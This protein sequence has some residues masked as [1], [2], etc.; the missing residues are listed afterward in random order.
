M[1]KIPLMIGCIVSVTLL[2]DEQAHDVEGDQPDGHAAENHQRHRALDR[3]FLDQLE[4]FV[5]DFKDRTRAN[6]QKQHR[7]DFE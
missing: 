7:E 4:D 2:L 6:R 5:A 1:I 3:V